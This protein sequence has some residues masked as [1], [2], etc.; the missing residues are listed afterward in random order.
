MAWLRRIYTLSA[1][2]VARFIF[3]YV[4]RIRRVETVSDFSNLSRRE[5]ENVSQTAR[6][7]L[8]Q[9]RLPPLRRGARRDRALRLRGALP[10]RRGGHSF[11]PR[12]TPPLRLGHPRRPHRRHARLQTPPHRRRG[13]QGNKKRSEE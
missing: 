13:S 10:L 9:A 7:P 12:T 3:Y 11:S 4:G 8:H 2:R 1:P 6:R 5:A